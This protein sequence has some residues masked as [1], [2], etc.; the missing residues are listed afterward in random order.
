MYGESRYVFRKSVQYPHLPVRAV[1]VPSLEGGGKGPR[2]ERCVICDGP[3][4]M[5]PCLHQGNINIKRELRVWREQIS[6][7]QVGAIPPLNFAGR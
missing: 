5:V 2:T 4:V 6:I 3:I 1:K 7:Q